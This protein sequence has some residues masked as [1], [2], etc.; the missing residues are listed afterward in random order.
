MNGLDEASNIWAPC[1]ELFHDKHNNVTKVRGLQYCPFTS[2]WFLEP[3][4]RFYLHVYFLMSNKEAVSD[5]ESF[6]L[7][8]T[9]SISAL[10]Y[11]FFAQYMCIT[12]GKN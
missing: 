10:A 6:C 5:P 4:Q 12:Y 2:K 7:I 9:F 3:S 1:S 11:W 8:M